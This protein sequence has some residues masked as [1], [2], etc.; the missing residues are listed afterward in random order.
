[1]K[2]LLIVLLA[3]PLLFSCGEN[4]EGCISGDCENGQG[5]FTWADG[6]K[7]VGEYKNDMQHG[8]VTITYGGGAKYVG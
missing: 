6:T 3:L 8:Q 7:Y 4:T 2:K 1:M 5:T